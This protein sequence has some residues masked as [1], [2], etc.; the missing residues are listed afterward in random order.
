MPSP[1]TGLYL[2]SQDAQTSGWLRRLQACGFLVNSIPTIATDLIFYVAFYKLVG[3]YYE[4][5]TE[6]FVY[7]LTINVNDSFGCGDL[8]ISPGTF[9]VLK[10]DKAG[11][12]VQHGNCYQRVINSLE[13][14][15]PAHINMVDSPSNC[16]QALYFNST[17]NNETIPERIHIVNGNPVNVFINM[18]ITIGKSLIFCSAVCMIKMFEIQKQMIL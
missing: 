6:Q 8:N 2:M 18:N 9:P 16:S 1:D 15:C 17:M 11:V 13:Y 3:N 12:F 14:T 7:A 10:G 5:H 4:R